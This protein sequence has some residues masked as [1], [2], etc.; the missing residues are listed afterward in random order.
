MLYNMYALSR[1][2]DEYF[3]T[4]DTVRELRVISRRSRKLGDDVTEKLLKKP[5]KVH[6]I[7]NGET[8]V[9]MHLISVI[10]VINLL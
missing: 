10:I 2:R 5:G 7:A 8:N 6:R 4:R 3:F 1:M 9:V